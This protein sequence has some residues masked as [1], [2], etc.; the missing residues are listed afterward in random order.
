MQKVYK[1]LDSIT[2]YNKKYINQEIYKIYSSNKFIF[3]FDNIN[4][5]NIIFNFKK[6]SYKFTKQYM[7]GNNTDNEGILLLR[8]YSYFLIG[9]ANKNIR[10]FSEY[11]FGQMILCLG[12]CGKVYIFYRWNLG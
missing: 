2:Y 1:F 10:I 7:F 12:I 3:K 5:N 8:E 11:Q 9:S 6:Y 4:I